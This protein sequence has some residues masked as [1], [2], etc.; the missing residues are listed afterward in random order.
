MAIR[1]VEK[2]WAGLCRPVYVGACRPY[3]S[4]GAI[5]VWILG[6]RSVIETSTTQAQH[7][8]AQLVCLVLYEWS[9]TLQLAGTAVCCGGQCMVGV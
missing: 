2:L 1:G 6:A 8:R 4:D 7:W 5:L 9:G 3:T